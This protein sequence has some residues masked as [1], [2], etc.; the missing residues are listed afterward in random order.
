MTPT[1]AIPEIKAIDFDTQLADE[2]GEFYDDPEGFVDFAFPW[3]EKGGVLDKYA[4]P[5]EW[6]RKVLRK[7]G[8]EVRARAFNGLDPVAPLRIAIASGHGIGKSTIT[9]WIVAWIMSTRPGCKGTVTANT[10]PQL[11]T[12]T[13]AQIQKW[14]KLLITADWFDVTARS[15]HRRGEKESWSCSAQT[16][17][18]ENS[19]SFAGQ[20]AADSTSFYIFDE[21]SNISDAIFEAA[22]G[23]LSDGEPMIFPFGNPTRSTGKF[24]RTVFGS[25]RDRWIHFSIDSRTCAMTNKTQIAEWVT[26]YGEDSDF[27]RVRVRGLAPRASD[28]QFIGSDLVF[29]A[30]QHGDS[31]GSWLG[32]RGREW[33]RDQRAV[34][35]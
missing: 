6:Q 2:I 32:V 24:F 18:D 35:L 17:R 16:C 15:I 34:P 4:G 10:F 27:V 21:A 23:G 19:E 29:A 12:K 3:A 13:W 30:Q 33:R 22:E 8:E 9:A 5:D 31:S 11:E 14:F 26:D 25:E 20:H 1:A 28:L 7:V